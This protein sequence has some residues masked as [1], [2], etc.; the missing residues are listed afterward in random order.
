M[1]CMNFRCE[2][3]R[4]GLKG[5]RGLFCR[6]CIMSKE[7]YILQCAECGNTF[8][9]YN[10]MAQ[11]PKFC[12]IG[13]KYKY[14]YKQHAKYRKRDLEKHPFIKDAMWKLISTGN[15]TEKQLIEK[16][17]CTIG[18]FRQVIYML[19]KSGKNIINANGYYIN[20]KDEE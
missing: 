14:N 6:S 3:E 1:K 8:E 17:N 2:K 16:T 13:C 9:K 11:M 7:P 15:Y 5:T 18:S 20:I 19:R 10:L 4:S 12:Q